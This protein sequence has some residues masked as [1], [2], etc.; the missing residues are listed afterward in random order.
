MSISVDPIRAGKADYTFVSH[1]HIDHMRGVDSVEN[2]F[3]SKETVLLAE[4]RG[5]T[6]NLADDVPQDVRLIESGHILGS[7]GLLIDDDVFYTGDFALKPRAFMPGCKPIRCGTLIMESTFGRQEYVFPPIAETLRRVNELISKLFS[8]GIP[9]VLMG[10]SLGKAQIL[11]DL[12]SSWDPIYLHQSIVEMN[13]AYLDLGV[14]LRSDMK[15]Y[16]EAEAN[17]LLTK[18]P[19]IL[20]SPMNGG[21]RRLFQDL[22]QKYGAVSIAFSGWS[23]EPRYRY[24]AKADHA[25]PLSDHCDFDDLVEMARRCDPHRIYTI[26]GFAEEF[27]AHLRRLGFD[28]RP[29]NSGQTYLSEYLS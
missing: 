28:A 6:L 15:S 12:F 20:I 14:D 16:E 5:F 27:A 18:R 26:H 25:F 1:A 3:A 29:L 22:K 7:R 17:G 2:I 23:V 11:S 24:M 19:W 21:G 4:R 13:R 8:R 9:V 10:Y